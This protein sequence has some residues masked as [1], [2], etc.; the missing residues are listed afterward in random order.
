MEKPWERPEFAKDL[1]DRGIVLPENLHVPKE[2]L[3]VIEE[4]DR[5]FTEMTA[6][7]CTPGRELPL[8]MPHVKK[9]K[10]KRRK[11]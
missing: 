3:S 8:G 6:S 2:E 10:K 7:G 1:K 9:R 5:Y 11:K 4:L